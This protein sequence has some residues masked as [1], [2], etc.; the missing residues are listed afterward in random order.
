MDKEQTNSISARF[1]LS[2]FVEMQKELR[3][4]KQ[5]MSEFII[6]AVKDKLFNES[7]PELLD[8]EIAYHESITEH[9]KKKKKHHNEKKKI[10]LKIPEREIDFLIET[11]KILERDPT[12]CE[13]RINLYKNKFGKQYRISSN[14]F[15]ELCSK[16]E[17]QV[18]EKQVMEEIKAR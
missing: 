4:T 6:E 17:D 9:L 15:F 14:D 5:N 18:K 3:E 13:G 16:A 10:L 11:Y 2:L 7:S 8:K 12:F 1:P